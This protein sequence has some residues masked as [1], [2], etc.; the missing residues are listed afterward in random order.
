[1]HQKKRQVLSYSLIDAHF[2][3]KISQY[4]SRQFNSQYWIISNSL[5]NKRPVAEFSLKLLKRERSKQADMFS[6]NNNN[7][8]ISSVHLCIF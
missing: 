7:F 2:L 3:S 5:N 6:V 4:F 1:M 8:I